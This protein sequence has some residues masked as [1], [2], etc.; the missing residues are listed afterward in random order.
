MGKDQVLDPPDHAEVS[1]QSA[2][3]PVGRQRA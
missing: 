1:T 3:L 2:C